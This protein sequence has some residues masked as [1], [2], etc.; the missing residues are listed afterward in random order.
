MLRKVLSIILVYERVETS[1]VVHFVGWKVLHENCNKNTTLITGGPLKNL[2]RAI[3]KAKEL[4]VKFEIGSWYAQGTF[5]DLVFY[6]ML[7]YT[8]VLL[9]H[10][11]FPAAFSQFFFFR[12]I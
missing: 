6:F 7:F 3:A 1:V 4:K 8:L 9:L 10:R 2:G 12:Y 5:R 11:F